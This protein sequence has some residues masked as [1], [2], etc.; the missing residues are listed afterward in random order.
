M[1]SRTDREIVLGLIGKN[2]VP[3][4][5]DTIKNICQKMLKIYLVL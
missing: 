1:A 5:N 4:Q 3:L 2:V